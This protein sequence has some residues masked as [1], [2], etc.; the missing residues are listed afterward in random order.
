M[1]SNFTNVGGRRRIKETR[2]EEEGKEII[3]ERSAGFCVI[4]QPN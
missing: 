1:L 2:N 4:D 3:V